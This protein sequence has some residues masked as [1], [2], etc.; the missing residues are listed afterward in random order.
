M[1]KR[2]NLTISKEML[3]AYREY[4]RDEERSRATVEKYLRDVKVFL[5][6]VGENQ[7]LG[8]ERIREYKEELRERYKISSANSM[9]AAV[10]SFLVFLGREELKVKLFKVQ[11]V[12]YSRPERE[13]TEKDYEK[14]VRAARRCGD[15]SMSM[16]LQTI[17]STGI[18]ISELRFITVESLEAGRAEIYNKGKSRVVLLPVEL[19]RMLKKYCREAGI[20]T[21]SI[22]VTKH[23]NPV[24]R[25]N[26]SKKMKQLAR[27]A[28]VDENRVFPHNFRHLFARIFYSVEK[29]VVRLMDL[30]GHASISTTRIYTMT[31]EDQPRRQ[32]SR[33]KLV[34]G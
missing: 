5:E 16:L 9:L 19:S 30:L 34:L 18:R 22:F 4:L 33:M 28:G 10:N 29:D 32:M 20:L 12:L 7:V 26:V 24:D 21:G 11:K 15:L 25:S 23:G 17:G 27:E 3:P 1:N 31:T 6:Y 2:K 8:K 14:L 13:M